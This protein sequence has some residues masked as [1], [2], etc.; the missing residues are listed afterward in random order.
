MAI[1]SLCEVFDSVL[2]VERIPDS[3]SIFSGDNEFCLSGTK[4]G[5][6]RNL[7]KWF[8][9]NML[10]EGGLLDRMERIFDDPELGLWG[11]GRGGWLITT[12]SNTPNNSLP[13]LWYTP[14]GGTYV[15]PYPRV[16]S[17]LYEDDVWN[18]RPILWDIIEKKVRATHG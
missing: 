6:V 2:V 4:G 7:T 9:S 5:D 14:E 8:R 11:F 1:K 15:A 10:P 16:S 17:R 3:V 13:L 18:L 12:S